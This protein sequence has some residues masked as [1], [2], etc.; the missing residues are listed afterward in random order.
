M[1]RPRKLQT[2]MALTLAL[3]LMIGP[4]LSIYGQNSVQPK[5]Y[6]NELVISTLD[7]NGQVAAIKVLDHLRLFGSGPVDIQD[8]SKF[9]LDSARNLYST[10]K[11]Q[12][13]DGAVGLK[14]SISS[15]G[16][17]DLYYLAE[18][19]KKELARAN[20]P[21]SVNL[22]YY[23]DGKKVPASDLSGKS[24]HVK[25]VCYLENLTG[26]T[27]VLEF[28]D[29]KGQLV[30]KEATVYTPYIVSLSGWEFDN[31]K[32][33]NIKAPGVAGESP[34]GVLA[35]VQGTTSVTWSIPLV[36][37]KYPAKQYAVLEAD[38]TNIEFKSFNIAVI[39]IL[40][41]TSE[42]DTLGSIQDSLNKLYG[43]FDQ[44]QTGVGTPG[45]NATLLFGLK[46]VKD[47]VG[48]ISSGMSSLG[49]N[50]KQIRFGLA[51]PAF[52]AT[53]YDTNTGADANGNKPGVKDAINIC[54]SNIDNKVIPGL[55]LQKTALDAMNASIGSPADA[56][57]EPSDATSIYNDLNYVRSLAAGTAAEKVINGNINPK[58][59]NMS[60]NLTTLKSGGTLVTPG[61]SM[62]FP[63]SVTAVEEGMQKISAG[64][65]KANSGLGMMVLGLGPVDKNGQPVKVIIDG[66]PGSILYAL[67]Y[68]QNGIDG[69]LVPGI[70]K[71]QEGTGKIGEGSGLAKEG[72]ASGLQTMESVPA[73]MS[74]M[75]DSV[76]QADSFLGKP[77]GAFGTVTYVYQT[78]EV[79]TAAAAMNYGLGAIALA[80]IILLL[81][82]RPPKQI[83]PVPA[84]EN[85]N[86]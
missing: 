16:Y 28:T 12:Q 62:Q 83:I 4:A 33:S 51:N 72:I 66:K 15:K 45:K 35:D 40:P 84:E 74:T 67:A 2:I 13:K 41:T 75:Q 24:G 49:T 65:N 22:E 27:K 30:K 55:G 85:Q 38:G 21:V 80:L 11:I 73:L 29:S 3:A 25:I 6:D 23:L 37:P 39:P 53:T 42:A 44:I 48:Q 46:S 54:K 61:G 26:Q 20:F 68:M 43:A 47:G 14:T 70:T 17:N 8:I 76:A 60:S 18:L 36:P 78:P 59:K 79:S 56:G 31:K 32:F 64:L 63:A 9:Q 86:V 5:I 77:E 7:D 52:N 71:I 57:Q 50:L 69:K 81:A 1:L 34:Q 19:N 82:G 58:L 10:D